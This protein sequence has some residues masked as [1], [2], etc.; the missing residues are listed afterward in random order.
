MSMYHLND[1][2]LSFFQV[3]YHTYQFPLFT[4]FVPPL[5]Q[6]SCMFSILSSIF[7]STGMHLKIDAISQ[8]L[9]PGDQHDIVVIACACANLVMVIHIAIFQLSR[10]IVGSTSAEC[11]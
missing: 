3:S 11:N 10:H 7:F 5:H 1:K 9:W 6:F 4:V 2:V 8:L